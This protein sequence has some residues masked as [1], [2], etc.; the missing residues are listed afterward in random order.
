MAQSEY[1]VEKAKAYQK[2]KQ[3]LTL[4]HLA[5]TP[6][7]L[8]VTF[9]TP[10]SI[11]FRDLASS[12]AANPYALV[13]FYFVFYSLAMMIFD[14][15]LGFYSG[16]MIE[17][18]FG[19]SNQTLAVWFVDFLKKTLLS[20]G[21]SLILLELLYALI[22]HFP[23]GWWFFAWLGYAGVS[24]ILGKL[25]PVLIVPLFY[26]YSKIGDNSL[27]KRI[28]DLAARYGLPIENVYSL[29]LS[30]TT[31]KANAAFMGM[32]KTK[33]V[34]LSD[35]LLEGF[36]GDEIE[37]VVAHELGHYKHKDIWKNLALGMILSFFGFRLVFHLLDP[38]SRAFGMEGALDV[39]SLPILFSLFYIFYLILMPLQNG[40]S[41]RIE[42]AADRFSLQAFPHPNVF[43]SCMDKLGKVNLADPNPHPLYEWFFYDHP[44]VAK[45]I[46]MAKK[47]LTATG[48][49]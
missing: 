13:F 23:A 3:V 46:E 29:N 16:F 47:E 24:Y 44:A 42:R 15:P 19:L 12:I 14:F 9:A 10:L 22:R 48:R 31:K 27:R 37:T 25:F 6:L 1:S 43:I 17:H 20:F 18:Q 34:V 2:K 41:R 32:G 35:T 11:Y 8:I 30:K 26:K 7:I 5:L 39:A 38:W 4:A 28:V 45:R 21:L 36:N 49:A 40:F 33:R